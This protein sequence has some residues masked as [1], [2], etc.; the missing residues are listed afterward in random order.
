MS[1]LIRCI[2]TLSIVTIISCKDDC[3]EPVS[4]AP[5]FVGVHTGFVS[6]GARCGE[7]IKLLEGIDYLETLTDQ[8]I[9]DS[10]FYVKSL[11][12]A[13]GDTFIFT[14]RQANHEEYYSCDPLFPVGFR[15]I[16]VLSI[17]N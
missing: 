11:P 10:L 9:D 3:P 7:Q 4:E 14:G 5:L 16:V 1:W 15:Q 12:I 13:K 2:V 17:K 6:Q 8:N